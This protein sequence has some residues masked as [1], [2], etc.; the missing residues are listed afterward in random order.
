MQQ[1]YRRTPMP[2]CDFNEVANQLYWNRTS[3]WVLSCKFAAYFQSTFSWKH[4]WRVASVER[5]VIIFET[6]IHWNTKQ[7]VTTK[8]KIKRALD[9]SLP[10]FSCFK[11][12][13]KLYFTLYSCVIILFNMGF[14]KSAFFTYSFGRLGFCF[15]RT[16][17]ANVPMNVPMGQ[18]AKGMSVFELGVANLIMHTINLARKHVSW[19]RNYLVLNIASK[20][21]VFG[22]SWSTFSRIRT[23]Y[24]KILR[25]SLLFSPNAGKYG[26]E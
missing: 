25:M 9:L 15:F 7:F 13:T 26:P 16:F 14:C 20:V 12:A 21:S 8:T 24:G 3:A 11:G 19:L 4:L 10:R 1:I 2:R 22:V 18:R 5:L 6:Y 23:E 17:C